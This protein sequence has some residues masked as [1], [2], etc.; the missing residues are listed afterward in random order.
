MHIFELLWNLILGIIGGI[1]SGIIVSR[2]FLIQEDLQTQIEAF[3]SWIRKLGYIS[4]FITAA[5][6]IQESICDQQNE[7][8]KGMIR[9]GIVTQQDYYERHKEKKWTY[10]DV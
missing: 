4:G 8:K 5:R 1:I 9:E 6:I 10:V 3:E 2:V 7:I